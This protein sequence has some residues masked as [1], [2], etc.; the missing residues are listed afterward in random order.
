M[1]FDITKNV[2][3]SFNEAYEKTV[4]ALKEQ[5]FGVLTEIN[6][7]DTL[8]KKLDVDF[9]NYIILGA[10]NPPFAH[11]VLEYDRKIGLLVPC[12]VC[13]WESNGQVT[14]SAINPLTM[15]TTL[16]KDK[17]VKEIAQEVKQRIDQVLD[18]I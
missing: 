4:N 17:Q 6:V 11:K 9:D 10:C 14:I 1:M 13:I 18:S 8:K 3:L 5:S 15:F 7:R 12:N 2:N 16:I